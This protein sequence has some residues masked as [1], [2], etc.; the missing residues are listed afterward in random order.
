MVGLFGLYESGGGHAGSLGATVLLLIRASQ[1][2]Q[3]IQAS[4]QGLQ[5]SLPFIERLE[6]TERRYSDSIPLDG[7]RALPEVQTLA[8][9]SV[10][11]A[12]NPGRPVLSDISF[13]VDAGEAVGIVGPSGA[14]K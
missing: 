7:E 6:E 3:A 12:Y 10:F 1:N 2:G 4:Y 13:A 14:G 11:F 8:F 9:E 5:Q